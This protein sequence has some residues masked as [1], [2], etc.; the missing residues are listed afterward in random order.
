MSVLALRV[1]SDLISKQQ[2][3]TEAQWAKKSTVVS[4]EGD[5]DS[6]YY[7]YS[8]EEASVP[9]PPQKEKSPPP[10]PPPPKQKK[11]G[12]K[13]VKSSILRRPDPPSF[14]LLVSE[15]KSKYGC[16]SEADIVLELFYAV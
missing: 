2:Q 15:V 16:L 8:D 4:V 11:N 5:A 13:L 1:R 12:F 7:Y 10:P 9:V 14:H 6:D 3:E